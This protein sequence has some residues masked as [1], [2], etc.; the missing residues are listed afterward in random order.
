[1]YGSGKIFISFLVVS[2]AVGLLLGLVGAG[3]ER[4]ILSRF[5]LFLI[6]LMAF[7]NIWNWYISLVINPIYPFYSENRLVPAVALTYGYPPYYPAERGPINGWLYGPIPV[8]AYLPAALVSDPPMMVLTGCCLSLLFYYVPI[9]G[10]LAYEVRRGRLTAVMAL[11]LFTVFA[12]LSNRLI[13]LRYVST[14]VHADAPALAFGALALGLV[15]RIRSD[16]LGLEGVG[17]ILAAICACLSKQTQLPLLIMPA[18]WVTARGGILPGLKSLGITAA[19][20][21]AIL[22]LV[23]LVFGPREFFFNSW[24][25]PGHHGLKYPT[26]SENVNVVIWSLRTHIQRP[27]V[28][29]F[30]CTMGSLL[31]LRW[32][33]ADGLIALRAEPVWLS[34][35]IGGCLEIPMGILGYIKRGGDFNG[36]ACFFYPLAIAMILILGRC[37]MSDRRLSVLLILLT[38]YLGISDTRLIVR[39]LGQQASGGGQALSSKWIAE[40]RTVL[41]YLQEHPGEAYFPYN[42]LDHLAVEKRLYHF[43]A[44]VDFQ[45]LPGYPPSPQQLRTF[46]PARTRI[47]GYPPIVS[48]LV[49]RPTMPGRLGEFRTPVSIPDLPGFVCFARS[50][51]GDPVGTE[52]KGGR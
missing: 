3:R 48:Q 49:T 20:A 30:L 7:L 25:V 15:G 17:A 19:L 38:L 47:I 39:N 43:E 50:T 51:N 52:L 41:R 10:I 31:F 26:I 37:A 12:L 1:M 46:I 5:A 42:I 21:I 34:F 27:L 28:A 11:L 16:R 23:A 6:P 13:S 32:G 2:C 8:L 40:E 9:M 14:S 44:G 18:L 24:T 33:G 36:E 29:I 22:G 4:P 35:L 45:E